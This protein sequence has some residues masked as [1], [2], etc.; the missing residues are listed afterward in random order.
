MAPKPVDLKYYS[1]GANWINNTL[2]VQVGLRM[3]QKPC[4]QGFFCED[5][6]R[7]SCDSNN[8]QPP[9]WAAPT[10]PMGIYCPERADAP[11]PVA[12]GHYS[13]ADDDGRRIRESKCEKGYYCERGVREECRAVGTYC[14]TDG[15]VTPKV[16][17]RGHYL[18][19][20]VDGRHIAQAPCHGGL[21]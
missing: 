4:E 2:G 5:G 7:N 8:T 3:D 17:T 9:Y 16:V 15:I 12:V 11:I 6:V 1:I 19:E 21:R 10:W 13:I 18:V 14:D 20:D